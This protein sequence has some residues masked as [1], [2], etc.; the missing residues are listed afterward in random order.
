LA[1]AFE[2]IRNARDEESGQA[3]YHRLLYAI[4]NS[5]AGTYLPIAL[6]IWPNVE[7]VL[8]VGDAFPMYAAIEAMIDLFTS[9]KPEPGHEF[10]RGVDVEE[11]LKGRIADLRQALEAIAERDDLAA[12]SAR[13]LL[14]YIKESARSS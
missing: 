2:G 7:A 1:E 14:S 5:H 6:E 10:Y 8:Q 3:A 11:S 13:D 9:F 4:G 12:K